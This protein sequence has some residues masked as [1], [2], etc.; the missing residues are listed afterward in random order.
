MAR[1]TKFTDEKARAICKDIEKGNTFRTAALINGVP[2]RTFYDWQ[3][4]FPQFSQQ[5]NEAEAKAERDVVNDL[6]HQTRSGDTKAIIFYLTHRNHDGWRPPKETKEITGA[7][8]GPLVIVRKE[9]GPA[10]D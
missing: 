2:E 9:Y 10:P 3:E 7:D 5:V 8:G 6:I 1:P 4:K